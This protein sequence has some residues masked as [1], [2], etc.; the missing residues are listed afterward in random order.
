MRTHAIQTVV[1]PTDTKLIH[2]RLPSTPIAEV[3]Q[4]YHATDCRE[5]QTPK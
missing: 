2:Y 5:I 3:Q 1:L 4:I